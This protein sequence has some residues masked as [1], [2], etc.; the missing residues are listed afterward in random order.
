LTVKI[1]RGMM[2][3]VKRATK[4]STSSSRYINGITKNVD[5]LKIN[6]IR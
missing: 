3:A 1:Q 2:K 4:S 6:F 5:I